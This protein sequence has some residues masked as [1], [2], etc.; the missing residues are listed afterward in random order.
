VKIDLIWGK[1]WA[2]SDDFRLKNEKMVK[3]AEKWLK[4]G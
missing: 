2:K 4:N 3:I 1:K